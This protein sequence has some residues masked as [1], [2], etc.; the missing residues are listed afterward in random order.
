MA[1]SIG[2]SAE[3]SAVRRLGG[4]LGSATHAVAFSDGTQVVLKRYA[5]HPDTV[6]VEWDALSIAWKA[7]LTVPEPLGLDV[8]G[9][10]F[11]VPSLVMRKVPGKP[12]LSF[13]YLAETIGE[14]ARHLAAVHDVDLAPDWEG[15]A[16]PHPLDTWVPPDEVP[17]GVLAPETASRLIQTLEA[18][19]PRSRLDGGV[20]NHGDF[21]PCNLFRNRK[22]LSGIVDWSNALG[23]YRAW[24]LS[25]FRIELAVLAGAEAADDLAVRYWQEAGVPSEPTL[26]SDLMCCLNAHRWIHMWLLGYREQGRPDLTLDDLVVR[27]RPF[28][29][30]VLAGA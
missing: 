22:R 19:L 2:I 7:G 1:S 3:V 28:V 26:A 24:D 23:G 11:E 18:Q 15:L 21:H 6:P 17:A 29:E 25:Y 5:H 27:L 12:G 20:F 13:P 4:G 30:R 10:W 16:R 14:V 8:E 9:R